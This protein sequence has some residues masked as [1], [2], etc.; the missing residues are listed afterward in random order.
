[1]HADGTRLHEACVGIA[2]FYSSSKKRAPGERAKPQRRKPPSPPHTSVKRRSRPAPEEVDLDPPVREAV[3]EVNL[4][5]L[6]EL[7]DEVPLV[8]EELFPELASVEVIEGEDMR[9]V[10]RQWGADE[11]VVLK[12][13]MQSEPFQNWGRVSRCVM[14]SGVLRSAKQCRERWFNH[15]RVGVNKDPFSDSEYSIAM[16]LWRCLGTKWSTI[17]KA[18]GNGRTDNFVKNTL[19]PRI[20]SEG[21]V[22]KPVIRGRKRVKLAVHVPIQAHVVARAVVSRHVDRTNVSRMFRL[23]EGEKVDFDAPARMEYL[24]TLDKTGLCEEL[25]CEEDLRAPIVVATNT[26]EPFRTTV[27]EAFERRQALF[28]HINREIGQ[29]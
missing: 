18:I 15:V 20:R 24:S 16:D 5:E 8:S 12:N 14:R 3:E 28:D 22:A 21:A 9:R 2:K 4:A 26:K 29:N 23:W 10:S 1:M 19:L 25:S 17:A 13:A 27:G 6:L 7:T 11:D